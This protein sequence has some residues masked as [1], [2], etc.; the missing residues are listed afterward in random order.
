M[1]PVWGLML[2]VCVLPLC[3]GLSVCVDVSM[4]LFVDCVFVCVC[5]CSCVFV[6]VV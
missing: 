5:L 1:C 6:V 4:L 2:F 3:F